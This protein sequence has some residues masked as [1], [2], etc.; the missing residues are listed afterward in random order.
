[1]NP[2][3]EELDWLAHADKREQDERQDKEVRR[4]NATK[5][6]E[7]LKCIG[8]LP[9]RFTTGYFELV[10]LGLQI[11]PAGQQYQDNGSPPKGRRFITHSGGMRDEQA[12]RVKAWIDRQLRA[13][14]R[15]IQAY[16]GARAGVGFTVPGGSGADDTR[17]MGREIAREIE[18]R[19]E[20]KCTNQACLRYVSW[21]WS[22]CAWCGHTVGNAPSVATAEGGSSG[23]S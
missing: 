18:Q 10:R 7:E 22:F 13:V 14:G 11:D 17:R 8:Y 6:E 1:M 5:R 15:D 19:I 20:L 3:D 12:L 21:Q 4:K 23:G 9:E 2:E 16:L